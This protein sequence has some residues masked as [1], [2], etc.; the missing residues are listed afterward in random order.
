MLLNGDFLQIVN[1]GRVVNQQMVDQKFKR[2]AIHIFFKTNGVG[3]GG[4]GW[5]VWLTILRIAP[6]FFLIV[7]S[8]PAENQQMFDQ[9]QSIVYIW[10]WW[11]RQREK[12]KDDK[13]GE[14]SS[15]PQSAEDSHN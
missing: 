8:G 3:L 4:W 10:S 13:Y 5:L 11:K 15:L 14:L 6:D 2:H 9:L 1:S 12:G 7:N